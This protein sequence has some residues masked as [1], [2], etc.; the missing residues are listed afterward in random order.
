[1]NRQF[2]GIYASFIEQ[3]IGFKYDTEEVIYSIFDRF[4]IERGETI[5]GITKDLADAW[6]E[7]K[8]NESDSYKF[9]RVLC[10]NQLSSFLCQTGIRSYISQLP[11]C[12]ST[13][14]P[15][16]FSRHELTAIFKSCDEIRTKKKS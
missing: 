6:K 12:K 8:P 3:F 15:Y 16:I 14:M 7:L 2:W 11:R 13:F 4:T 5:V 1:M 10:L 9:H